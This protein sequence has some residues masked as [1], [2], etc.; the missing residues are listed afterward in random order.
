MTDF[1]KC[2]PDPDTILS[3]EPETIGGFLLEFF[4][5]IPERDRRRNVMQTTWFASSQPTD[6]YPAKYREPI[7]FALLEAWHWLDRELLIAPCGDG[8]YFI[9]RRGMKLT[10]RA[11][12]DEYRKR[13]GLPKHILH[14]IL[15]EKAWPLFL[16]GQY[17]TA[18]FQA[19]KEIEVRVRDACGFAPTDIG[20]PLMRKAF[21]DDDGPLTDK[22][23]PLAERQALAHLF[24]GAYGRF[25]N[26]SGHR[27]VAITEPTDAFEMLAIASNLLKLVDDRN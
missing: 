21:A 2:L 13:S 6:D 25:R 15:I 27:H 10:R 1:Q 17:E 18:V 16:L 12:V 9:T 22:E 11:D 5:S 23:E 3:L 20:I 14:P 8:S 24:A 7:S 4:H 26:P 19:F